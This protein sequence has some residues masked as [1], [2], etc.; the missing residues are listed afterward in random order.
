MENDITIAHQTLVDF[1]HTQIP[2]FNPENEILNTLV[3]M[4]QNRIRKLDMEDRFNEELKTALRDRMPEAT[5]GEIAQLLVSREQ[6]E[7]S[8]VTGLLAPFIPKDGDRIPL[9]DRDQRIRQI[10]DNM[11]RSMDKEKLQAVEAL[12]QFVEMLGSKRKAAQIGTTSNGSDDKVA[13]SD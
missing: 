12:T 8:K 10:D 4:F 1:Q 2:T 7:N 9:L 13:S 5:W 6:T 11:L 3:A